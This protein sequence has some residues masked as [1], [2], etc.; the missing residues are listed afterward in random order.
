MAKPENLIYKESSKWNSCIRKQFPSRINAVNISQNSAIV[1]IKIYCKIIT[2]L[3]G[4][5][6]D[7]NIVQSQSAANK[8][9]IKC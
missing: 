8:D 7:P 2:N 3:T 6:K 4:S 9:C 1:L 5:N